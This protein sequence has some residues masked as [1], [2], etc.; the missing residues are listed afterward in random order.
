MSVRIA[1]L[2]FLIRS[3]LHGYQVKKRIE[4]EMAEWTDI[5]FGSIYYALAKLE[6][7]KLIRRVRSEQTSGKP[8][9]TIYRITE[10]G[11]MEFV[12]M[13]EDVILRSNRAYL[14]QD[15]GVFFSQHLKPS[16]FLAILQKR[17]DDH[18][19]LL[20]FLRNHRQELE[21]ET[22]VPEIAT[23]I[24]DHALFHVEAE[25]RWFAMLIEKVKQG[26]IPQ[27]AKRKR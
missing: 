10:Q 22:E 7:E 4:N 12:R 8:A 15:V 11:R 23:A 18:V 25:I 2:G 17:H 16:R 24:I 27:K 6:Q 20:A 13:I 19:R 21:V 3:D 5:K 1:I 9:R 26:R 14:P